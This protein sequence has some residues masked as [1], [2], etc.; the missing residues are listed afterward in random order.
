MRIWP[1]KRK[2]RQLGLHH[3]QAMNIILSKFILILTFKDQI[4]CAL[5]VTNVLTTHNMMKNVIPLHPIGL[6][7]GKIRAFCS[8][9]HSFAQC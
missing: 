7:K 1:K 2:L 9:Q 6:Q 3:L 8:R 4:Y 5:E